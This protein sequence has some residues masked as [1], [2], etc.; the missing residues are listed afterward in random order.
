LLTAKNHTPEN[1]SALTLGEIMSAT[2]RTK[3]SLEADYVQACNCD[4][5]CPCEFE[6]RPTQGFCNGMGAWRI[7]RGRHGDLLLD[8]LALGFVAHWP[9]ALHEGNGTLALFFEQKANPKQREALM[10]IATGQEGGMP[11]EIIVK[12]ISKLLDPQYVAFDFKIDGP[13]SGVRMGQAVSLAFEPIKNPV[14]GDPEA[15]RVEHESGFLFKW[16]HV[17]S[18][19]EGRAQVGELNFDHPNKAGFVTQVKY[20]N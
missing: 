8:G 4:Y 19:K 9:G 5:G 1:F 7:N 16:A 13:N 11:F 6:A 20:G 12:T 17:V 10:R 18:A 3:W 2:T 15:I 14:S